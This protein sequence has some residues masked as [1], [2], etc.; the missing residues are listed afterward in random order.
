MVFAIF[1]VPLFGWT[2]DRLGRRKP[3]IV[4][5]LIL[6]ALSLIAIAYATSFSLLFSVGVLGVS[7]S[8]TPALLMVIITQ[9]LPLRLSGTGFGILTLCQNVGIS[10]G[11]PVAGYL[12]QTTQSLVLTFSGISLFAFAGAATALTI[13]AK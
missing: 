1:F 4:A 2:S 12:M 8:M 9:N 11:P 3:I 10:L 7:A 6:M 13:R 5:G